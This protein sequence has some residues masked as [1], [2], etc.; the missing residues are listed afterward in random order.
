MTY[1]DEEDVNQLRLASKMT[2]CKYAIIYVN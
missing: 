2:I 1:R